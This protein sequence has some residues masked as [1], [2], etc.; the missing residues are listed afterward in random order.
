MGALIPA[1][2]MTVD[3]SRSHPVRPQE[4]VLTLQD[5]KTHAVKGYDG[6]QGDI[7]VSENLG[8][9]NPRVGLAEYL[10]KKFSLSHLP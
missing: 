3:E 5:S 2:S 1:P 4:G 10:A 7:D 8:Q 6:S 9:E